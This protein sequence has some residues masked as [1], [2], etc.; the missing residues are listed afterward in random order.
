MDRIKLIDTNLKQIESDFAGLTQ[1]DRI[2]W[3]TEITGFGL[4]LRRGG[5]R[6]WIL[7]YK[8]DGADRRL[9]LGP[10]PDIKAKVAR[11]MARAKLAEVW[12]GKDPQAAKREAKARRLAQISLK[13][14]IDNFLEYKQPKLRPGSFREIQRYLMKDWRSLHGWPIAEIKLA[15]VASILDRLEKAGPVSAAH[16][17]TALSQ[18]FKWAMG[19][20]YTDH[21]P[22]ANS[23]NPDNGVPR[24]RVLD[25]AELSSIWNNCASDN[26][27]HRI[28]R[29]LILTACRISEVG[30][31]QWSEFNE[32]RTVW[33]I[34]G[35][36]VKNKRD[37]VLPLPGAFWQIVETVKHRPDRDFLFGYSDRGYANWGDPKIILDKQ[38]AVVG[39]THH[40]IRRTV[41]TRMADIGIQ[42]HIIEAVLNHQSGHKGGVAG[43]YNRSN[44][45]S[46]VKGALQAWAR[47]VA[48]II[49]DDLR[50]AHEKFLTSGD[51]KEQ[52][53]ASAVFKEAIAVTGRWER[54]LNMLVTGKAD[55]VI[56]M[57]NKSIPA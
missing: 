39:W 7:Q 49:D 29:L 41:A 52:E 34:P 43:I 1:A 5:G 3:D 35:D 51:D 15:N 37:H 19:R 42:P 56:E 54:Y 9:K 33:T 26:D 14:V 13:V 2:Y 36:R 4:R 25:D 47:Y 11:E 12:Q 21:N 20:G 55:N 28:I 18:V 31:M 40:D 24:E 10:C 45:K 17:R 46:E 27:Y 44:Y 57:R 32:D 53:E 16:S 22:V 23:I 50:A 38:C 30:G 8:F 48:L 6:A